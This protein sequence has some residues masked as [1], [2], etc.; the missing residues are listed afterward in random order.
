MRLASSERESESFVLN[1]EM[2]AR[3]TEEQRR[4]TA[5]LAEIAGI[6]VAAPTLNSPMSADIRWK[7]YNEMLDRIWNRIDANEYEKML[8]VGRWSTYVTSEE[9]QH[10]MKLDPEFVD[11]YYRWR[12]FDDKWRAVYEKERNDT[13]PH[14]YQGAP[15]D[16]LVT[17]EVGG[18]PITVRASEYA[19]A[20]RTAAERD[21]LQS[22]EGVAASG[23][24]AT[25]GR[26]VGGITAAILRRDVL[27]G[28]EL[29]AAIGGVGD[30][31]ILVG[32]GAKVRTQI[33]AMPDPPASGASGPEPGPEPPNVLDRSAPAPLAG[34]MGGYSGSREPASTETSRGGALRMAMREGQ[35]IVDTETLIALDAA[36]ERAALT[37]G[38]K[39]IIANTTGG[40]IIATPTSVGQFRSAGLRGTV[41]MIR[42]A[43]HTPAE[44]Q[45]IVGRLEAAG[46]GGKSGGSDRELVADALLAQT[47]PNIIP[48]FQT[49][50][51][52]IINGLFRLSGGNPAQ[53]EGYNVTEYLRY[54]RGVGTFPLK[55]EGRV[56]IV[57]PIQPIRPRR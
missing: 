19:I 8:A 49:S 26:L 23:P 30:S 53:L 50:D 37:A 45:A 7:E 43:Q 34:G 38:E 21:T 55:V 32:A 54:R 48:V 56:L 35:T 57:R 25:A 27:R 33:A 4:L 14:L 6:D 1:E 18:K 5:R 3:L 52:G 44:R 2:H 29:G 22:I 24:F 36:L 46:V 31:A 17:G 13:W 40:G 42:L 20:E 39:L 12:K 16:P 28:S 9:L 47:V 10:F 15:G 11:L 51:Q 41:P